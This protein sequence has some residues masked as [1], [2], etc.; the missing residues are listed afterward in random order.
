MADEQARLEIVKQEKEHYLSELLDYNKRM[1]RTVVLYISAA[2][3][4]I[5]LQA[6]DKLDLSVGLKDDHYVWLAFLFIFLNACI[7]LHGFAQSSWCMSIAKFIHLKLDCELLKMAGHVVSSNR[8]EK[9]ELTDVYVLGWDY[10]RN[11]IKGVAINTRTVVFFLWA[12][13]VLASSVCSLTFVNVPRFLETY[14]VVGC[15]AIGILTIIHVYVFFQLGWY[16][17]CCRHYHDRH[18]AFPPGKR[19]V[20]FCF[21]LVVTAFLVWCSRYAATH[22]L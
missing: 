15:L 6:A 16:F 1:D 10:W 12:T 8:C 14:R 19:F 11:E 5:G 2:Y 20:V 18:V 22:H 21:A 3:A 4:A 13:L 17:I 7:L 9:D